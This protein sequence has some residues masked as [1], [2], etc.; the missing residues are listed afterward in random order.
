VPLVPGCPD[1]PTIRT[2]VPAPPITHAVKL[3][4]PATVAP[5]HPLSHATAVPAHPRPHV[6][7]PTHVVVRLVPA[8]ARLVPTDVHVGWEHL[9]LLYLPRTGDHC[10]H[11]DRLRV[12][13]LPANVVTL[14][15]SV[16]YV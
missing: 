12:R 3:V 14:S 7:V 8:N 13:P 15:T 5:A 2:S 6:V 1:V 11:G 10:S 9:S 16:T 4:L